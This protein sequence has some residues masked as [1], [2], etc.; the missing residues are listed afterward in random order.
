M[1]GFPLVTA[2]TGCMN[3][4][5]NSQ[6]SALAG[7]ALGADIIEDDIRMTRDGVLVLSHDDG[8]RL[9]DGREGF[10]SRMTLEELKEQAGPLTPLE[11]VLQTV[12]DAGR[13]MNLDIKTDDCLEL[14]SE[15]LE[16]LG[17][18]EQTFL[19]GCEY[20]RAQRMEACNPRIRKLLN[21]SPAG[22]LNGS[23]YADAV[24]QIC[25]HAVSSGC[26]GLNLAVPLV[27]PELP[28]LAAAYGL[29]V[30]VW[31]V[32]DEERMRRLAGMGVRSITTKRVD[33]LMNVKRSR[34]GAGREA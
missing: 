14:L 33:L 31:T 34:Q 20:G 24:R 19:S 12:V 2:H 9:R 18:I 21:V 23:L 10:V 13:V 32:D 6:A 15:R 17:L 8:I 25:E 1:N 5:E 3:T 16:R 7:L 11:P 4:P 26:F 27:R 30:Y 22:F 28:E 29:D